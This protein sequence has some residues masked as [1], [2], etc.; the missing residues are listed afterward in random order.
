M[1]PSATW[2]R[3]L[4]LSPAS[5]WTMLPV[6]LT[7][8][9]KLVLAAPVLACL[10][11]KT[12]QFPRWKGQGV[13]DA[14]HESR[15]QIHYARLS[16]NEVRSSSESSHHTQISQ[17]WLNRLSVHSPRFQHVFRFYHNCLCAPADITLSRL[18]FHPVP[19]WTRPR[20]VHVPHRHCWSQDP[21]HW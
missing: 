18:F 13:H 19:C 12:D 15:L 7:S 5:T 21:L 10:I 9:K 1:C 4:I 11:P 14:S 16:P 17:L 6:S 8:W 20:R 3:S 2:I